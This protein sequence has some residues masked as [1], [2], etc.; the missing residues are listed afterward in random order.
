MI[1]VKCWAVRRNIYET[2]NCCFV[3]EGV[4]HVPASRAN[5]RCF[6][7]RDGNRHRSL[8]GG[9]QRSYSDCRRRR[10]CGNR[11][12]RMWCLQAANGRI[13]IIQKNSERQLASQVASAPGGRTNLRPLTQGGSLGG[14]SAWNPTT[15]GRASH[16]SS[17]LNVG[18]LDEQHL[19]VGGQR[20]EVVRHHGF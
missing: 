16:W 15:S 18:S 19:A 5:H 13:K 12:D 10:G 7:W 20:P 1:G 4:A 3:G 17:G 8:T 6:R 11:T 2:G 14:Q 9:G